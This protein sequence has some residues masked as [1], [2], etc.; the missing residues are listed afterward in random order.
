MKKIL[1]LLVVLLVIAGCGSYVAEEAMEEELEA[2]GGDAEVDID[3]EEIS[4]EY[5][6]D[7]VE[8]TVEGTAGDGWCDEDLFL[9]VEGMT[10]DGEMTYTVEVYGVEESGD[11]EGLC[12]GEVTWIS[13][14]GSMYYVYYFDEDEE[15]G[16]VILTG[17]GVFASYNMEY[18]F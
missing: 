11:Y 17:D 1:I 7:E 14:D 15:H 8:Y 9:N 16:H 6:D 5:S 13:S 12:K 10:D 3:G 4:I 18:D 2:D